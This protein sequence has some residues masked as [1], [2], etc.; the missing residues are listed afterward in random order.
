M[1]WIVVAL[2]IVP[3]V[4]L[5]VYGV[6]ELLRRS[7]VAGG[8]KAAWIAGVVFLPLVGGAAY[9]VFRPSRPEDIRGFGRRNRQEQRVRQLLPDDD[10]EALD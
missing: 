10:A 1:T 8:R 4:A 5:S 6:M 9:L 3:V 7:D 2:V